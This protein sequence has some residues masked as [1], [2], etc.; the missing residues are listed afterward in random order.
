MSILE[1]A[2]I[3]LF[4]MV[5]S[6]PTI[7]TAKRYLTAME[8]KGI[9]KDRLRLVV[10]RYLPKADIQIKDAE[11]VLG[12]KVY[13]TVPND[14]EDIISS[15]NKGIPLIKLIPRAPASKAFESLVS[16]LKKDLEEQIK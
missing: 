9:R 11:R 16:L 1:N 13:A 8:R 15:I 7:K 2:N 3:T 12:Q 5:L 10:N 6:L 4:T 14:Y